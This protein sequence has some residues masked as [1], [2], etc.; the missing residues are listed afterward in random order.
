MYLESE[1][2]AHICYYCQKM[3]SSLM[4]FNNC[5]H[6]ICE[7]CM[8]QTI[9]LN[10]IK[11]LKGDNII[12][13]NCKCG[14]GNLDQT[15]NDIISNIKNKTQLDEMN[16]GETKDDADEIELE[17]CK[18]HPNSYLNNYCIECNCHICKE[19]QS[20]KTNGHHFHRIV[21]CR[22]LKKLIQKSINNNLYLYYNDNT[23]KIFCDEVAA[24]IQIEIENN[25]NESLQKID[26]LIKTVCEFRQDYINNY[27]NQLKN[28]IKTFKIIKFYYMNYYKDLQM[29]KDG[30]CKNI[31]FLRYVNN[32]NYEFRGVEIQHNEEAQKKFLEI[33]KLLT[34]LKKGDIKLV[35]SNFIFNETN[36]SYL[37]EELI[38]N[39]HTGFISGIVELNNERILTSCR[40]EL[41]MKIY[42]EEEDKGFVEKSQ[43][44][45]ECG[46]LLYLENENKI[47]SGDRFGTI[48]IYKE[49]D[50]MPNKY[51]KIQTLSYHDNQINSLAKI[52]DNKI[53]SVGKDNRIIIW[54]QLEHNNGFNPDQIIKIDKPIAVVI[55]LFDS[56]IVFTCDD[57]PIH[58]Y[59]ENDSLKNFQKEKCEYIEEQILNDENKGNKQHRGRV[60]CLCQLNNSYI[61]SG[62]ADKSEKAEDNN[63]NKK[64]HY[65]VVWRQENE[66]YICSQILK[67]HKASLTCIIQ[68]RDGNFASS[69]IDRTV[70]IWKPIEN[71][72]KIFMYSLLYD[73]TDYIH[74]IHMLI[75][76]KDDRLCGT[77][78][79][80]QIVLWRNRSGSY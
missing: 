19:C 37:V 36:R 70:K 2:E 30:Q 6:R 80:N 53:V 14:K 58:I 18:N 74:G 79:K 23:F 34:Q 60:S 21:Q 57:G 61:I 38:N 73:L 72:N 11:D 64:E 24:K 56:R 3:Y 41:L 26:S 66:N 10:N 31:N 35:T 27:K 13:V 8:F 15:L 48:S 25:L 42:Q 49:S 16:K 59:K 77:S 55:S 65:I 51:E 45:G 28:I 67:N 7:T 40:K 69:S 52:D 1:T 78:S 39:V 12:T 9:F 4:E 33:N 29:A 54:K 5:N 44:K 32:I 75:Q 76:L 68:L 62:G 43:I 47:V 46:C 63:K 22:K 20:D 17:R 71:E 50:K